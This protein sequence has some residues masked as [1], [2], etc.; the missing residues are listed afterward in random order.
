MLRTASDVVRFQ[1]LIAATST[2]QKSQL[3]YENQLTSSDMFCLVRLVVV[4]LTFAR[5]SEDSAWRAV[6]SAR[7]SA[8]IGDPRSMQL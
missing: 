3:C 2:Y 5:G 8:S 1:Q 7:K 4:S 6:L